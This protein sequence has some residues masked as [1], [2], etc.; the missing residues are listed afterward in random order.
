MYVHLHIYNGRSFKAY[1]RLPTNSR[2]MDGQ[3]TF[4]LWHQMYVHLDPFNGRTFCDIQCTS[5]FGHT[6]DTHSTSIAI[7]PTNDRKRD[8]HWM[9]NLQHPMYVHHCTYK[10][11]PWNVHGCLDLNRS[12]SGCPLHVHFL[13]FN[14]HPWLYVQWTFIQCPWTFGLKMDMKCTSNGRLVLCG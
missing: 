14:E 4:N 12:L 8:A 11:Y 2:K 10:R 3:W 7:H 6:M 5:T 1:D 9:L 13:T